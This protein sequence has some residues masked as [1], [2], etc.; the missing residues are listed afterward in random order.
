MVAVETVVV[1][2]ETVIVVMRVPLAL[3]VLVYSLITTRDA[4]ERANAE[5]CR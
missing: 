5:D 3:G 4:W 2:L 1:P